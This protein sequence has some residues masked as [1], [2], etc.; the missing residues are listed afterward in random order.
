MIQLI[1]IFFNENAFYTNK[2]SLLSS[3]ELS[4]SVNLSHSVSHASYPSE[5][6]PALHLK[7]SKE[8]SLLPGHQTLLQ[9]PPS[10]P[11]LHKASSA[12]MQSA[13]PLDGTL[14]QHF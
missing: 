13:L 9:S 7:C 5:P 11:F 12:L 2:Q 10:H 4:C 6:L 3:P 14:I 1:V 8:P